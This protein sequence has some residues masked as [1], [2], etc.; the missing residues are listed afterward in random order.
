MI[1]A[2]AYHFLARL[3]TSISRNDMA[4]THLKTTLLFGLTD[5]F[6]SIPWSHRRQ[7]CQ[8]A[9]TQNLGV[10]TQA[11]SI[12]VSDIEISVQQPIEVR[13]IT[14]PAHRRLYRQATAI[15]PAGARPS[16]LRLHIL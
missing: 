5:S 13:P 4:E 3:M 9:K 6:L 11:A 12:Y 2:E 14:V 10:A 15:S 8:T 16:H 1:L 7:P